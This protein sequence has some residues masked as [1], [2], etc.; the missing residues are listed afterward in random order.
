MR[1]QKGTYNQ[2]ALFVCRHPAR[3]AIMV[4]MDIYAFIA[5]ICG[6]VILSSLYA[7]LDRKTGIPAVLLLAGTGISIQVI[8]RKFGVPNLEMGPI[9]H[10]LGAVGLVMIVLEAALDLKISREKFKLIGHALLSATFPML[11]QAL[12]IAWGIQALLEVPFRTAMLYSIPL[13]IIS[14]AIIIPSVKGLHEEKREYTVYEAAF[15]D[16][17]G[18]MTFNFLA[19]KGEIGLGS[20]LGFAGRI[21]SSALLSVVI[22]ALLLYLMAV[23]TTEIR[24]FLV[25]AVLTLLYSLGH[26]YHLPSLILVMVFGITLCNVKY[27]VRPATQKLFKIDQ[28]VVTIESLKSLTLEFSFLLR[29][30]FFLV[31]GYSI[32]LA[33]LGNITTVALGMLVVFVLLTVRGLHQFIIHRQLRGLELC[34]IPRGLVTVLLFYSIPAERLIPRF[35]GGMVFHVIIITNLLMA[36]AL[37]SHKYRKGNRPGMIT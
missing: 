28:L 12:I 5:I 9:V 4:S 34:L 24:L 8:T 30:F 18:I 36:Y 21:V 23:I 7:L 17:I 15:N 27:L 25:L 6:L 16:I 1:F 20:A 11:T 10:F 22:S 32:N 29:T 13:S 19:A 35:S 37:M 3:S 2:S 26:M 31:F 33:T 14:S